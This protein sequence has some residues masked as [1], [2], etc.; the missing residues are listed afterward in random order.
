MYGGARR[1][2]ES[3]VLRMICRVTKTH[4]T[5][6]QPGVCVRIYTTE[7]MWTDTGCA[8]GRWVERTP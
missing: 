1:W 2:L 3:L 6:L 7:I 5:L 4:Y 8:E